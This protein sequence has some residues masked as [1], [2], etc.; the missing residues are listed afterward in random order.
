[1]FR[2]ARLAL[3]G[4]LLALLATLLPAQP[5]PA[6]TLAP[7]VAVEAED[8]TVADGWKVVADG[9]GN[10]M[11][12]MIGFNH[13][14]GERLLSLD[15]KASSGKASTTVQVPETG[16]YKLWV[17]YE[18][19]AFCE[20]RFRVRI[21]QGD[22][23]VVSAIVGKKDSL[24]LSSL[25]GKPE[26][27]AQHDPSW[28]P[29]GLMEEPVS[30]PALKAGPATIYLE[31]VEQPQTLGVAAN[32]NVDCLYLT[33]DTTDEWLKHYKQRVNL[34]P[35]LEAFRDTRGARWEMRVTNK[36]DKAAS[37]TISHV[38]NRLPWGDGEGVVGKDIAPGK[39]T[40]WVPL[41]RQDTTHFGM[42]HVNSSAGALAV[43]VRPVGGDKIAKTIEAVKDVRFYLPPYPGKGDSPLTPEEA[44][45]GILAE[46]K[47]KKAPGKVP[48]LPLCYGGWMP[49]GVESEYGRKYAQL[50]AA[51][52][53][54]SLH[55]AN[56]GPGVMKNLEAAGIKP[57]KSWSISGYR[58]PPT[59]KNIEAARTALARGDMG[60]YLQWYDYGD[61]IGFSEWVGMLVDETVARVKAGGQVAKP[62]QVVQVMWLAWLKEKRPTQKPEDYWLPAWGEPDL[63][64][65]RPDSSAAAALGNPRLYVDSILFYEDASIAY[66]AAGAKGVKGALGEDVLCGANYSCHPFYYPSATAYIKWFRGGAADMGRHSE[67]FWQV[68]Q[69][70]PM[71]NGYI[72][73]HFRSGMRDNPRAVLR[74]YTMPHAPGNTDA[75]FLR[76]AFTHVAHGATML[77][78]FGI[79]LN[80]SFT[81][82]HID[83]RAK[84]RFVAV[85]DVTHALG[86]VE[87]LLPKAKAIRSPVALLVSESTER[88]DMA[89]IAKDFAGHDLFGPNFRKTR[90]HYHLERLG[91]W[92]AFTF[93]GVSPDLI[94]EEDLTPKQL[95][96]YRLL[97]VVGDCLP[98]EKAAVLEKWVAEGGT[99]LATAGAGTF[100]PYRKPTDA[101]QK[102]FGL[103]ERKTETTETFFRPRQELPFLKPL[104]EVRLT[105]GGKE[106]AWPA[107]AVRDRIKTEIGTVTISEFSDK[108]GPALVMRELR[109]GKI[110]YTAA[111]PGVAYLWSG[112]QPPKVPDRG[113]DTHSVPQNWDE[114]VHNLLFFMRHASGSPPLIEATPNL[115]DARILK[116]PDGYVVPV[117]NYTDK[118]SVPVKLRL[119]L[120]GVKKASS[121]FAGELKLKEDG[122]YVEV[123]LPALGYGD[124]L[125]L[126]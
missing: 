22:V 91:L 106:G 39:A 30:V 123:T 101:Y 7:A 119:L 31:G 1:M 38:Y 92:Q 20:C 33:R 53:M 14:S 72:A 51:L 16:A 93:L 125:R 80:E 19:P 11:V 113:P 78:F 42:T 105:D 48:T 52:G 27:K 46:L 66:V 59:A 36:A 74:Q 97:V 44:I 81:E 6:F 3:L 71:I 82:N 109:K 73:E 34:Y 37:F 94:I 56:S 5:K 79:G 98:P 104:A 24:R 35:I 124:I 88:W 76:S 50:Y 90:L 96:D 12:D 116:A 9:E 45:D 85:R 115:I 60:K 69:P 126:E 54:R 70:G 102:L 25:S 67:Y 114:G 95:E 10:Y 18:Y 2:F 99:L 23:E 62:E 117:A 89:G 40:D 28:G 41:K 55:P 108:T 75:S 26:M 111:L 86:F 107:L 47:A 84:S 110:F 13:I 8:F 83:H 57:S 122:A 29:E 77:D 21:E 118:I 103:K 64:R 32:R 49:L 15:R 58:N 63:T 100:D 120:K 65:L 87:D 121:A 43:E 61:E 112:L 17:R 68:A 4:L